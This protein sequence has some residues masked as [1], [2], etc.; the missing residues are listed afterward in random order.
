MARFPK[1][2]AGFCLW[3]PAISA[4][5]CQTP[6]PAPPAQQIEAHA[7]Q[8]QEYLR[9]SQPAL[10]IGEYNAILKLDP[11]NI[12]AQGNLGVTYFFQNDYGN[13]AT[14]LRAALKLRPT[15]WKIEALLGMS[16]KRAGQTAAAQADLEKCFPRLEEEKLRVETGMELAE[17]YYASSNLDKAAAV[18][19]ALRQIAPENTEVLYMAYRIYSDQAGESMLAMAMLAPKSARMHQI[20]G[21]EMSRQG[22]ITGAIAHY[23]EAIQ[24][25]PKLPGLRF[26]LAEALNLSESPAD[27]EQ[28]EKEYRA[29]LADNPLEEKAEVRLGDIALRAAELEQALEH[30]RRAVQIQPNDA[31]ACLGIGRVLTQMHKNAEAETYLQRAAQLEPF[32]AVTHYRLSLVYRAAG[33]TAD[34]EK[35]LAEFQ[36]LKDMKE[37]LKQVYQEMRLQ[38]VKQER[39]SEGGK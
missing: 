2:L 24:L 29:A 20:M 35:E 14:H 31:E 37:R 30:Y 32:T 28:V 27:Q 12:D 3:L 8:A 36:K 33:R 38:P 34:A 16:E 1:A 19:A 15:L 11:N 6:P 10:A 18:V 23:R 13:A 17:I 9:K 4:A 22:N 5:L 7:R 39:D 26:E 25:D 21:H